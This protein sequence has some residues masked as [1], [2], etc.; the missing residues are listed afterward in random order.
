MDIVNCDH[1]NCLCNVTLSPIA[2]SNLLHTVTC[3][4]T[5]YR[6]NFGFVFDCIVLYEND[7]HCTDI[8]MP[9]HSTF[10]FP[11]IEKKT[12][13]TSERDR[14]RMSVM[15]KNSFIPKFFASCIIIILFSK[16]LFQLSK[17]CTQKKERQWEW[18][19]EWFWGKD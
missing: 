9:T 18:E 15:K 4:S 16:F 7:L 3:Y 6:H 14:E 13:K 12:Q 8:R 2:S 1:L 19:W 5:V 11:C 17:L 10:V